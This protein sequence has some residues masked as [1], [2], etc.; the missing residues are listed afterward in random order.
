MADRRSLLIH[1]VL[2][3]Q[4]RHLRLRLRMMN[5]TLTSRSDGSLRARLASVLAG[6]LPADSVPWSLLSIHIYHHAS[7]L[8]DLPTKAER[9]AA[10]RALP[11][12]IRPLVETEYRRIFALRAKK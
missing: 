12:S 11:D 5:M 2:R 9:L 10:I 4:A 1:A 8:F 7:S 6:S 3:G